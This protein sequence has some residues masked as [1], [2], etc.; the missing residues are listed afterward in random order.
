MKTIEFKRNGLFVIIV[1]AALLM[2]A[3]CR[4][5]PATRIL[6]IG[7]SY[8]FVND[9]L[10]KQ[11]EGLAPSTETERIA[12]GGYTLEKHWTGGNALQKIRDGKWDFVVLQ[13]QSQAPVLNQQKFYQ[14][15][16]MFDEEIRRSGARTILLMTW[17]RP[18][19]KNWGVTTDGLAAAFTAIGK[20]LNV[21]V[22]PAGLAFAR[23][24][25][26]NPDLTL[27][28]PDGHPTVEGTYLAACVLYR[29]IFELNPVGNP[30]SDK[31]ISPETREF[32]QQI[33]ADSSE[34]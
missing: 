6:F 18:D 20:E 25:Q 9:G 22:A 32:L 1:L 4:S 28:S 5:Q 14:F 10:D 21:K 12:L 8:T 26:A 30:Y 29:K 31:K 33:A 13:E 11:L 27:C 19:S 2:F 24:L 7:N 3:S 15:A 34:F 23:S 17:E 16:R